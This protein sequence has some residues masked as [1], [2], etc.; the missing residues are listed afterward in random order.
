MPNFEFSTLVS[1]LRRPA[2]D[3]EVL[4]F[5]GPAISS[6]TRDEYYGSIDFMSDG[7]EA[8][9][10][11]APWVAPKAEITD[12]KDLYVSAFHLHREGHD[13]YA[14]YVGDL[15]HGARLNDSEA[16]LV[17]KLG[18][19]TAAGGGGMSAVLKR[20]IAR[21]IKYSIGDAVLNIQ[22]DADGRAEMATL[23]APDQKTS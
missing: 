12:A 10:K 16:E 7:V 11:E 9:F 5:F 4:A 3:R 23:F 20:P 2:K 1:L 22:F 6:L 13:G 17:R 14:G 18:Q 8:V 15:P 21:W 19:P